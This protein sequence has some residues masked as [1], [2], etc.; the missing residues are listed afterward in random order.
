MLELRS[1]IGQI[2][3]FLMSQNSAA[4]PPW[5][6]PLPAWPVVTEKGENVPVQ[7]ITVIHEK[8]ELPTLEE[9]E[10]DL[11]RRALEKTNWNKR[12]AAKILNVSERT[13]YRKIK[14]YRLEKEA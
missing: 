1:E 14:E 12:R 9:A 6:N 13:L 3:E 2:K 4:R 5:P 7:E 8:E 10:R 11:I